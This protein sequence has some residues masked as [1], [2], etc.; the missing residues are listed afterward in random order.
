M[1]VPQLLRPETILKK[2]VFYI[3]PPGNR[4][5]D[6]RAGD[7]MKT[8]IQVTRPQRSSLDYEIS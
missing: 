6:P 4:T 3:E 7:F 5:R 2:L 1:T 8:G